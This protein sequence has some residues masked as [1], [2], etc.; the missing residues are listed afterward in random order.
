MDDLR[1]KALVDFCGVRINV[2][3]SRGGVGSRGSVRGPSRVLPTAY[4]ECAGRDGQW[5]RRE[6]CVTLG[7][8]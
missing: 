8:F 5:G 7:I 1:V 4:R 6:G 3:I 2:E